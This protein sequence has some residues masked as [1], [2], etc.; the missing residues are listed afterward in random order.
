MRIAHWWIS[1]GLHLQVHPKEG[2]RDLIVR[3]RH[4]M[5]QRV[6]IIHEKGNCLSQ[7]IDSMVTLC[8]RTILEPNERQSCACQTIGNHLCPMAITRT[9]RMSTMASTSNFFVSHGYIDDCL[10]ITSCARVNRAISGSNQL[11]NGYDACGFVHVR[12]NPILFQLLAMGAV[13]S[14]N[15]VTA[16]ILNKVLSDVYF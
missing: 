4:L 15:N 5:G 16:V 8:R 3:S 9:S 11:H 1:G 10:L 2:H 14:R 7:F 13:G 6:Q 12:P